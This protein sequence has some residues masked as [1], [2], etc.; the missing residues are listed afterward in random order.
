MSIRVPSPAIESNLS[1]TGTWLLNIRHADPLPIELSPLKALIAPLP[2]LLFPAPPTTTTS[3]N[4]SNTISI[5]HT[6]SIVNANESNTIHL[7]NENHSD[8]LKSNHDA[9][10]HPVRIVQSEHTLTFLFPDQ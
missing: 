9:I 1:F 2:L 4:S 3:A 5:D 6:Y 7:N 8:E 10:Y